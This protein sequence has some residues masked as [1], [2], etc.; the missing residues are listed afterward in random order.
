MPLTVSSFI[1]LNSL[2][3][4]SNSELLSGVD[5]E[6]I[7]LIR[8]ELKLQED[9]MLLLFIR[10]LK[11]KYIY[12]TV[13][14]CTSFHVYSVSLFPFQPN[15]CYVCPYIYVQKISCVMSDDVLS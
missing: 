14:H 11:F 5:M 13:V 2:D 3:L 15:I 6:A 9:M 10:L 7:C 12:M 4:S 1:F 8:N